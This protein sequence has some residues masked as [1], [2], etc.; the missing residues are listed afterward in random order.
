MS[1]N[2]QDAEGIAQSTFDDLNEQHVP[3]II[4]AANA[5]AARAA[6]QEAIDAIYGQNF[7][8][9]EQFKTAIYKDN[10]ALMG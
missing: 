8:L 2:P 5:D 9:V 4:A 7:Q 10:L 1:P 3:R 6:L